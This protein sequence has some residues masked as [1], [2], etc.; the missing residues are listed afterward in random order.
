MRNVTMGLVLGGLASGCP[1][2][3]GEQQPTTTAP[4]TSIGPTS[5]AD[6]GSGTTAA[7]ETG[8]PKLDV[9]AGTAGSDGID[10]GSDGCKKVDLLFVVDDSGSM[11]DEQA[12]LVAS[13]PGFIAAMQQELAETE[14]YHIGVVT[15]DVYIYDLECNPL[16]IGN[17][18]YRTGGP[19]ASGGNCGPYTSGLSFMTE[20]DDLA[21]T[22]ACAAQV[23]T[24]G[25]GDEHPME[26]ML[27]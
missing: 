6:T 10:G 18:V 15:S 4:V 21:D 19:D 25:D 7:E 2:D 26:A 5:G 11:A 27:R 22:F 14:G 3:D 12:N 17:L 24:G 1:S 9:M 20:N 16:S 23:G 13:F 8:A